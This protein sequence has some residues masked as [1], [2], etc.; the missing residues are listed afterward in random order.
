MK[1]SYGIPTS[2]DQNYLDMEIAIH[3]DKSGISLKP[4]PVKNLL[5][6]IVAF[7]GGMFLL[8]KTSI[9]RGPW[10]TKVIFA[11]AWV[12]LCI[13]LLGTNKTKTLGVQRIVSLVNY[14]FAAS[15]KIVTRR[16]HNA[17]QLMNLVGIE[18]IDKD[19][20]MI[21]Y[22]DGTV[23][24]MYDVV[25]TASI[26][27]FASHKSSIVDHV[28]M[29]YRKMPM[30]VTYQYITVKES[31]RVDRQV[32]AIDKAMSE[33]T[34]DDPDL[35]AL[36]RTNKYVYNNLIGS[37]F[38]S[39]HQY[40][41]VQAENE[42]VL[43][44]AADTVEDDCSDSGLMFKSMERLNEERIADVYSFIYGERKVKKH[45]RKSGV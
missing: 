29:F 15:R 4:I 26:L 17:Q 31:Q 14:L 24:L 1:N 33:M 27:L 42:E 45:G 28:D 19:T 5:I 7:L 11:I 34:V 36:Q 40:F 8:F 44:L 3:G 16:R 20:D 43:M 2:L 13:I 21:R 41:V 22:V 37:S 10:W 6:I 39:I 32:A 23:G 35:N 30:N 38:K 12:M 9:S 25:G 18:S